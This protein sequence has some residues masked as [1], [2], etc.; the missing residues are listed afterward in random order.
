MAPAEDSP[1]RPGDPPGDCLL[2][3]GDDVAVVPVLHGRLEAA[4]AVREAIR[5]W[6]PDHVV[7]ELPVTLQD[8]VLRA[9]DRLPLLSVVETRETGGKAPSPNHKSDLGI[10]AEYVETTRSVYLLVE[11]TEPLV[12][13][14]RT[15][16]E[17]G[18]PVV[19]GDRDMD[20]YREGDP[21]QPEAFPDTV[22]GARLGWRR[23]CEEVL[24]V[25]APCTHPHDVLRERTLAFH[26]Q[27]LEGRVLLVCGMSHVPGV[28]R[29]LEEVQV[30]PL[31][32]VRRDDVRLFHL[33]PD[34]ARE[35]LSEVPFLQLAW[36]RDR[37]AAPSAPV[38]RPALHLA[39]VR[40]ASRRQASEEQAGIT[41]H[42]VRVLLQ[43]ARNL[44]L[45]A[46]SLAPDFFDLLLAARGAVDD[47]FAWWF[48]QEAT[49]WPGQEHSPD[50]PVKRVNLADLRRQTRTFH[51]HRR[52]RSELLTRIRRPLLREVYPGEWSENA[53]SYQCS[54]PPEDVVIEGYAAFLRQ[55]TLGILAA[56]HSRVEPFTTSILDGID[57]RETIRNRPHDG[58]LYV[59]ENRPVKGK[60]GSVILIFDQDPDGAA[61]PFQMTWQ[62]EHD[63]ESDMAFY[64]TPPGVHMIGPGISRCEYGGLLMTW[65]PHRMFGVWE[66]PS[67]Q[68]F[69]AR[70]ERL[71]LAG[72]LYSE[73]RMVTYIAEKPPRPLLRSLAERY[74][75][76]VVYLPLGQ[77]SPVTLRRIRR[78]HILH[79]RHVRSYATEFIR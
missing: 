71:L 70:H 69:P 30:L 78:F 46:G 56:E 17:L 7:V 72:I 50:L 45:L 38:D 1:R 57:L 14:V 47:N 77:L 67:F 10:P 53:G 18:I 60:V 66:E 39:L 37:A 20:G 65:P 68:A 59:R 8:A 11:P 41:D 75:R 34:A 36:E 55:R 9:V 52:Q 62:G 16:R 51:F 2:P 79:G 48:F 28:R 58:R 6:R 43:Y 42:Q 31:G 49:D 27:G 29:Y 33:H 5:T 40:A 13:A 64:A 61:Y 73:E 54:H 32:R 21:G 76:K 44:A 22:A 25:L 35:V 23:Y 74:G 63:Q 4:F 19:F 24:G 26:V 3:L 12:E 15:A